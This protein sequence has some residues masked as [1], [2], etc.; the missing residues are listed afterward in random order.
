[1][2]PD[3]DLNRDFAKTWMAFAISRI[4][5]K[6][7]EQPLPIRYHHSRLVALLL[8]VFLCGVAAP[9]L[10]GVWG[11]RAVEA[12]LVVALLFVVGVYLHSSSR[13]RSWVSLGQRPPLARTEIRGLALGAALMAGLL[14]G[15]FL[16]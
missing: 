4:D 5:E 16:L 7:R 2:L 11:L 10:G 13:R 15:V 8:V 1:M 3:E 12:L 14:V 6:G 9:R